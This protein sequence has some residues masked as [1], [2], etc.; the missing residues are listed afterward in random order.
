M[1]KPPALRSRKLRRLD[2]AA[3]RAAITS[4]GSG[5]TSTVKR[6]P[7]GVTSAKLSPA[8]TAV[9]VLICTGRRASPF[10][11]NTAAVRSAGA[12]SR[13]SGRGRSTLQCSRATPKLSGIVMWQR[14][15]SEP[16]RTSS[17]SKGPKR[18]PPNSGASTR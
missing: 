7:S 2:F 11:R 3:S 13:L 10:H 17:T 16:S 15:P 5:A 14:S 4:G 9:G 6:G 1:A 12:T 8:R 18:L